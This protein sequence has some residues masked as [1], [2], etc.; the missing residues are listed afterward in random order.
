MK[1]FKRIKNDLKATSKKQELNTSPYFCVSHTNQNI[2]LKGI[3]SNLP[4]NQYLVNPFS[5]IITKESVK[6]PLETYT[7]KSKDELI[8]E[9]LAQNKNVLGFLKVDSHLFLKKEVIKK[10]NFTLTNIYSKINSSYLNVIKLT[11]LLK[12]FSTKNTDKVA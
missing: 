6:F 8:Q 9:I 12:H 1:N 11:A 10:Y 2:S 4:K 7:Y 5:T 3:K